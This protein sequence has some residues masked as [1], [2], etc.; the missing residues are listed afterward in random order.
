MR[1]AS[2]PTFYSG[3]NFRSRLEAR[4]AALFDIFEWEW[5]YEPFDL[6]GWIPD[7][8]LKRN[9]HILVEVKPTRVYLPEIGAEMH[10]AAPKEYSLL[11]V[12]ITPD[13]QSGITGWHASK[14]YREDIEKSNEQLVWNDWIPWLD[15][16]PGVR[17]RVW[18][19][20]GNRV[21]WK[22]RR[23]A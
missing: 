19:A 5:E 9:N 8:V 14:K 23:Y 18:A 7:F 1:H 21:Q 2:I 12:G 13:F 22:G 17:R 11:L 4:W 15:L 20:A 6:V 3:V 10:N 16:D